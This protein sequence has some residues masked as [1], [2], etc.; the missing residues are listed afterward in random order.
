MSAAA[1]LEGFYVTVQRTCG[2][3]VR[4]GYLLGPHATKEQA[5]ARVSLGRQLAYRVDAKTA[6]DAFGVTRMVM[7]PGAELPAGVLNHLADAE[8]STPC[9]S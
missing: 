1:S 8:V 7:R 5:E 3:N 4:T 2:P 9:A 6:F